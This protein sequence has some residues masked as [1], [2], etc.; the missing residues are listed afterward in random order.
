MEIAIDMPQTGNQWAKV[1]KDL[2]NYFVGAM[3]RQAVEVSERRLS[4]QEFEE[5]QAA[6]LVEVRNFISA[7]AFEALPQHLQPSKEQAIGM[8]WVLT[9]KAKEDGSRKAKARAVL[10]GYQDPCYEHRSTTAPVM[11]RSSRQFLIQIAAN[12]KWNIFK[13]DV[14]G[15]FLQGRDYPSEL[16]CIPCPE[17][18]SQMNIPAGSITRL[19]KACY[20]LVDAPLEWY[21]TVH[22]FLQ[23]LGLERLWSDPCT[24]VWREDGRVQGLISGHVDDFL[25][26]GSESAA[27]CS[28][29]QQ[30]KER[31]KWGDW[32][33]NDFVQCGV[34]VQKTEEGFELSQPHYVE[35]IPEIPVSSNRRRDQNS[36]TTGWEKT[37]LRALLGALSWHGQQVAPHVSA[38]VGLLLSETNTSNVGTLLR[39]NALLQ[40]TKDRREHKMLIHSFP[41]QEELG[42]FAWVDAASQ[43]RHDGGSTAGLFIGLAPLS[44]LQGHVCPVTP[45]VWSSHKVERVCRSPGAAETLAAVNGEDELFYARY[46][47]SEMLFGQ[48][49]TKDSCAV[50]R[51]VSGCVVTDSRNVYDKLQTEVVSI[52]GAEKR[53]NLELLSLKEAQNRTQV[54]IRWVHSEAQLG[55]SLTKANGNQELDRFYRMGYQWRIVEDDQMRSARRRRVEGLDPL[56]QNS[57]AAAELQ[58]SS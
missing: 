2:G 54:Q 14:S 1:T 8:R 42:L 37:Q 3:K 53:A 39:A 7:G 44:M 46:Q 5:F 41:P 24:W 16:Y 31:F 18:C 38:E 13:G 20:G 4:P 56:Q 40:R 23:T 51:R 28:I 10:L 9:W 50:V 30:I 47:F 55:N 6:K 43:N 48:V 49:D 58:Q 36:S 15:A 26:T 33:K 52:R 19:R 25:F 12:N 21:R 11:T 32:D 45:V 17:I 35:D 57:T 22:D 29:I 34:R 27:W